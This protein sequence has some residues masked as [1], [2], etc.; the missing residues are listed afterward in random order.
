[1]WLEIPQIWA[2]L[3]ANAS[4]VES[5]SKIKTFKGQLNWV[6]R[7]FSLQFSQEATKTQ[8]ALPSS[9]CVGKWR[10]RCSYSSSTQVIAKLGVCLLNHCQITCP[11]KLKVK[12][13]DNQRAANVLCRQTGHML[14]QVAVQSIPVDSHGAVMARLLLVWL[15]Y[16]GS[17]L[18]KYNKINV[19]VFKEIVSQKCLLCKLFIRYSETLFSR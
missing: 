17:N 10:D 13:R 4:R 16:M 8:R 9:S 1:M 7:I 2:D 12:D 5:S 19:I 14:L 6:A 18:C 3:T 11:L 15:P